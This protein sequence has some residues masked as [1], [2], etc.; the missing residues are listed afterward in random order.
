[1]IRAIRFMR[2]GLGNLPIYGPPPG[3]GIAI[4]WLLMC[5]LAGATRKDGVHWEGALFGLLVMG[6]FVLPLLLYGAYD[7]G[8]GICL[9]VAKRCEDRGWI[10]YG[11]LL[12][13]GEVTLSELHRLYESSQAK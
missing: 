2:L 4:F 5:T 7:R 1:M 3:V 11:W 9:R 6:V 12:R 13:D 8:K 10:S